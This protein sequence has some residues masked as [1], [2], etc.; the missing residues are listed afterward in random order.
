MAAREVAPGYWVAL[1]EYLRIAHISLST[2][3]RWIKAG[4]VTAKLQQGKYYIYVLWEPTKTDPSALAEDN[5]QQENLCLR[6]QIQ[7]LQQENSDL[8]MLIEA[9]ER[10]QL[11]DQKHFLKSGVQI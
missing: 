5:L 2:A 11:K 3:R 4:K 8:K 10:Q 9:Y 1:N 6:Q 7:A